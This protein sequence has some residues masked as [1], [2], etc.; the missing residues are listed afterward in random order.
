MPSTRQVTS[1]IKTAK[2]ISKITKAMEMVSASKMKRAQVQALQSRPYAL[3]IIDTLQTLTR[4]SNITLHPLF[5]QHKEGE[6]LLVCLSTDRGLSGSFNPN[7]FRELVT[8]RKKHPQGKVVAVGKKAI[9]FAKFAGVVVHAQFTSMPDPLSLK[10][11]LPI[12]TLILEGYRQKEFR[13]VTLLFMD[14]VNTLSQKP[15]LQQLLPLNSE[16]VETTITSTVKTE[17]LF[18]PSAREILDK[19]VPYYVENSV[20]QAFLESKASEHS[21]RMVAMK[22]ASENAQELQEELQLIYNKSRQASITSEL[23]DITTATLT[24]NT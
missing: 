17:Y 15:M 10:D 18:E 2:N 22:N 19:L 5:T 11:T 6:E 23:L 8:W 3:A 20:F 4:E 12:T 1:R 16:L 13:I 7:L 21:A 14:F 24:L 9:A